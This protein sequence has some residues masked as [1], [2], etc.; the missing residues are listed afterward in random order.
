MMDPSGGTSRLEDANKR[1]VSI[2]I[3]PANIKESADDQE[4]PGDGESRGTEYIGINEIVDRLCGHL[5]DTKIRVFRVPCVSVPKH[6][7][8]P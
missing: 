3:L 2:P 5:P 1:A 6:K 7:S 8:G 4:A